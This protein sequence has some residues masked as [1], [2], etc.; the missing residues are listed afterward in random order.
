MKT[1]DKAISAESIVAYIV[2]GTT[3][4]SIMQIL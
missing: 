2:L 3:L 4:A 1:V